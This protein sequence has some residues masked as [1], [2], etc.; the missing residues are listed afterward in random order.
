MSRFIDVCHAIAYSH[1]RGVLH[2]DLKPAN[3]LLGPY[4]ETLVVDWGLAKVVGRDDPTPQP[5]AEVTLRPSTLS[6]SSET[7]AGTLIGTPIVHEPRAI[8]RAAGPR[9]G[10]PAIF[11][12]SVQPCTT[13]SPAS[14][15]LS[16][17]VMENLL[18]RLRRGAIDP[19]RQVNPRVPAALES[20]VMKAMALRPADRYSSA[21]ALSQDLERWLA[22]EPVSARREPFSERRGGGCGGAERPWPRWPRP[23]SRPWPDSSPYWSFRTRP[24]L[25]SDWRTSTWPSR[26]ANTEAANRDT[27]GCQRRESARFDLALEAIKT[28]HGQ[29]SEDL[30]LKEKQFDGLRTKM[31]KSATDFYERLEDLLKEQSDQRSR[32]ALGQAYHD[33]GELTARIGSQGDALAALKRGLELRLALAARCGES[34]RS[35]RDAGREPDR[36]R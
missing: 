34:T 36:H 4:G 3:I 20:I 21:Q 27:P 6:G 2:R 1:S 12:A 35:T 28:F 9:S 16:D 31:L 29:V 15:P 14:P 26:F 19:P 11:T 33:I 25:G 10:R 5:A 30:L 17:T 24:I 18:A 32:A 22:D 8:A 13:S 7:M 23:W